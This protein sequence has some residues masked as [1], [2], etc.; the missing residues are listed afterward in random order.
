[1]LLTLL[2]PAKDPLT[3]VTPSF[4]LTCSKLVSVSSLLIYSL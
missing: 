3:V 2:K 4:E 1:M